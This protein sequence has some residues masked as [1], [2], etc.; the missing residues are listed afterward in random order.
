MYRWKNSLATDFGKYS[1]KV[2]NYDVF[3]ELTLSSHFEENFL[4]ILIKLKRKPL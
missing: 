3:L 2:F 4:A 1:V